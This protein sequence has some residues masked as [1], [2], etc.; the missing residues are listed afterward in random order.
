MDNSPIRN[1]EKTKI[2]VISVFTDGSCLKRKNGMK[3]GYGVLYPGGELP[4]V[5]R[6]FGNGEKTNNRAEF[7]AIYVALVQIQHNFTFDRITVYSDSEYCIKSLTEYIKVWEKNGWKTANKKPVKNQ[8]IIR[9]ISQI[10][11]R[12]DGKIDFTHVRAHTKGLDWESVN[13]GLVDELAKAGAERD[14]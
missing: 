8:D 9:P 13:N 1:D 5:S 7:Q 12:H 14:V 6:S 4:N 10:M 11:T 3:C 2:G